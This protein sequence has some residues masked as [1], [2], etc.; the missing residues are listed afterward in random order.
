MP[1]P[2]V[3]RDDLRFFCTALSFAA[4]VIK[5]EKRGDGRATSAD[6]GR[7]L[8]LAD[9]IESFCAYAAVRHN[10]AANQDEP[11]K[12]DA[13]I[14]RMKM[15]L[16]TRGETDMDKDRATLNRLH[17]RLHRRHVAHAGDDEIADKVLALLDAELN[18]VDGKTP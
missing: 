7:I 4:I 3:T 5:D 11:V 2:A 1:A 9:L 8:H 17:E 16:R 15:D 18:C 14:E 13:M 6:A 10:E 12:I